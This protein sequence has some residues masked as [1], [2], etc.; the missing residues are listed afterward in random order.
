MAI[1]PRVGTPGEGQRPSPRGTGLP[2]G[3]RFGGSSTRGV[4]LKL[5][6]L[7]IVNALSV[8]ALLTLIPM[9]EWAGV[10]IVLLTTT[11]IDLIYLSRRRFALKFLIPGTLALVAFQLYPVVYTAYI[12]FTNYGTGNVLTHD[13]AVKQIL[14]RSV[15]VPD[16]A[17]RYQ[18]RPLVG[19]DGSLALLLTSPEGERFLGTSDGLEPVAEEDVVTDG[20]LVR[21]GEYESLTLGEAQ[22][23]QQE[24]L[25]FTVPAGEGRAI[26]VQTFTTA[27]VAIQRLEYDENRDVIVDVEDGTIYEPVD[28]TYTAPD[29]TVLR[30]GFRTVV[31]LENFERVL[32]SPAIRGPFFRV[33][34][35]TFVFATLATASTFA[36]GLLFAVALNDPRLR[37]RRSIRALLIVPYALP[38]FMTALVWQGLLN[39]TFGPVNRMLDLSIPWLT[40][41]AW[42][43]AL[44]RLSVLLVN[45]WLGF[46]Y[47]FLITTGALQAI[48]TDLREA[49]YVDGASG[50]QAFRRIT[51]PLLLVAVGPLLVAS[52]AFSFNNF[53]IIY[54]LT[55][56][57]PPVAGV[58]I[59]AG[60]TDLLITLSYRLAFETGRGSDFGLASAVSVVIFLIVAT[61]A[62]LSFRQTRALE[63]INE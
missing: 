50:W 46:P 58:P 54:L 3:E 56:G 59:P 39:T 26:S 42:Y 40:S 63:E 1:E 48:P 51:F 38:S 15:Y 2:T 16:D 32:T 21:V 23:R 27:A 7:G 60:H 33:F 6:F 36:L 8:Y 24:L 4:A 29:G 62:A 44:P 13:Q 55:G 61:I 43:G 37:F 14:S 47:M 10:A 49:A 19:P 45:L 53:N 20:S 52:Y 18:T 35:W 17:V 34:A 25:D 9:R 41:T 30:P 12:A 28:G 31:G 11:V 57:G 22:S 5:V